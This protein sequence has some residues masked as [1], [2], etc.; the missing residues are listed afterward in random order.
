[1]EE[2]VEAKIIKGTWFEFEHHST[3]EG[4]YW[5]D[6]LYQ[7][8]EA[9]WRNKI[10][11]IKELGM[12][13]IVLLA[14]SLNNEAYFNST[15]YSKSKHKT[16]NLIETLLDGAEKLELKVFL[17]AGYYGKWQNPYSN[18]IDEAVTKRAFTAIKELYEKFNS[19]K[20]FYGWYLPDETAINPYFQEAFINYVNKYSDYFKILDKTKKV[21]I[22]PYGTRLLSTDEYFI[23]QLKNLK[24]DFIAYQDEVGVEKSTTEETGEF[25]RKLKIAHDKANGPAL[26]ADVEL[27]EFEG[28]VYNSPLLPASF[29]RVS[30]QLEQVSPYVETILVYQYIGLMN[31]DNS[32]IILGNKEK[33]VKLY[34]DYK[35]F[36]NNFKIR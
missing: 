28:E 5:N 13:Y 2:I 15:V 14:S 19:Y 35:K 32:N 33:S 31:K 22:A 11:E 27:F 12:E 24:V 21:L 20:S 16:T 17:S 30:K 4:T 6:S 36:L 29:E 10:K 18:M 23:N 25:Y 8:S 1:M 3:I 7:F 9:N 26:W 34:N